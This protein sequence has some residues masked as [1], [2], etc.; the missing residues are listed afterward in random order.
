METF[1]MFSSRI[2][3][4]KTQ[5]IKIRTFPILLQ[6]SF[7]PTSF[8][9]FTG[10]EKIMKRIL[11]SLFVLFALTFTSFALQAQDAEKNIAV[12]SVSRMGEKWCAAR[13]E[14]K[15]AQ[16]A[17]GDIDLV[18]L[19]DSITHN[20]ESNG[21]DVWAKYYE[22][23]RA[24]NLGYG[25]DRTEHVIWRI[26]NG[27][28]DGISPKLIVLM[29]GTNNVGHHSSTPAQTVEGIQKI[30]EI[31][32][33]KAPNAKVLLLAVFPRS[34]NPTDDMRVKVN[35]INA[36]LPALADNERVFY[37]DFGK[38]FLAEDGTLPAEMMRDRLHPGPAGY[39]IWAQAVEPFV[40]KYVD[41]K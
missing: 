10:K 26:T 17:K 14:Q 27:E 2:L 33:E 29:I 30:L 11:T 31:L 13:H 9:P 34:A 15:L 39:E 24:I 20:W 32:G 5:N 4:R 40:K 8:T 19:G 1:K 21:K 28:L 38:Q 3:F 35:E 23:R 41:G 18:F 12:Q 37:L 16:V 25:A 36:G 22:N 7:Y 6:N